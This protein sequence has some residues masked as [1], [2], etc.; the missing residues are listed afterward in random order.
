MSLM[1][2]KMQMSDPLMSNDDDNGSNSWTSTL[3]LMVGSN[4]GAAVLA[5]SSATKNSG[6]IG[7]F[8]LLVCSVITNY[9]AHLI[10]KIISNSISKPNPSFSDIG[11]AAFGKLGRSISNF[12][13]YV[14]LIGIVILY[15][16][17]I[18]QL[19]N[20]IF[21]CL[22]RGFFTLVIGVAVI[23]IVLIIKTMKEAK[24]TSY[25]ALSTTYIAGLLALGISL[26]YYYS[27]SYDDA[28]QIHNFSNQFFT[29][30][31]SLTLGFSVYLFAL[32]AH[33]IFP[34]LYSEM[35]DKT[36]WGLVTN[37]GWVL[38]CSL[39]FPVAFIGY[40]VYGNSLDNNDTILETIMKFVGNSGLVIFA[41]I[42]FIIHFICAIPI[43][44]TPCLYSFNQY[45]KSKN[46]ECND[47][48]TRIIICMIIIVV[49]LFFPYL[50]S[51]MTI[52]SDV[53]TS[54][55]AMILPPIFYWKL[56][57]TNR[58]EKVLAVVIVVLGV[59]A[60]VVGIVE[61][62]R[63]LRRNIERDPPE[64]FFRKLFTFNMD[65]CK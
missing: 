17:L 38:I 43:F 35:K 44:L 47:R 51:V 62:I 55:A 57:E 11:E 32:G 9:T 22:P 30:F 39:Y 26:R 50:T 25:L 42:L 34:S 27:E 64:Y 59:V 58:K 54:L 65:L 19:L 61:A 1:K 8:V 53:S 28:T 12:S 10:G 33:P 40:L 6:W 23:P 21:P 63:D 31:A 7:I 45:L 3:T 46:V 14:T 5:L 37:V 48:L 60:S 2:R 13:I 16:I 52:I 18:G 20:G 49:A 29:S 36:K 24:W 15:L 4:A 41:E 56:I